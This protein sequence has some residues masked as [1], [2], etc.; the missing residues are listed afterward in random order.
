MAGG[1]LQVTGWVLQAAALD[2]GALT[3][4]QSLTAMSLVIALPLGA[5]ITDQ[6]ITRRVTLGAVAVV[7]GIVLFLAVGSP[8]GGTSTPSSA[9]WW[10]AGIGPAVIVGILFGLGR[11]RRGATK[12]LLFGA[13]AGV[14]FALQ[15]AVTKVFVTLIGKGLSTIV[16]SWTIY[17]LIA[18]ALV[19]FGLQQSA[20]KT[21]VLAPAMASSNWVTLF[22]SIVLGL[23]VFGETI[24]HG[25]G[26]LIPAILGLAVA[27]AGIILL[28]GAKPPQPGEAEHDAQSAP[29]DTKQPI[30]ASP[31]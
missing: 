6:R 26:R 3:V 18:S 29:G 11:R 16:S 12:A 4:V 2:Q 13:A 19:G 5:W 9:A 21:G 27:L 7:V 30:G 24:S 10:A 28:A 15:A 1:A 31:Q 22:V 25:N 14:G 8:Q 20:L 17:V 23:T